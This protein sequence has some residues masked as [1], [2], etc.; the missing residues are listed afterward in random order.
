MHLPRLGVVF[1]NFL[2][3]SGAGQVQV[4]CPG[5]F[6]F[7]GSITLDDVFDFLFAYFAESAAADFNGSGSATVQ[8]IFEFLAA[9][10]GAC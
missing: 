4:F 10:F 9:Y 3:G 1:G 6:N 7:S 2:G 8:D 5:D